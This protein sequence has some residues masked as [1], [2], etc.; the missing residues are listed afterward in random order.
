MQQTNL[1]CVSD[2]LDNMIRRRI[3][4]SRCS[5]RLVKLLENADLHHVLGHNVQYNFL[6]TKVK[7]VKGSSEVAS[8]VDHELSTIHITARN[9][10]F[11][12][13][14]CGGQNKNRTMMQLFL[15]LVESGRF[16]QIDYK[17]QVKGH[18]RNTVD[19]GFAYAKTLFG[20]SDVWSLDDYVDVVERSSTSNHAQNL[21]GVDFHEWKTFLDERYRKFDGMQKFH[22]FRFSKDHPGTVM[23][24]NVLADEW[25]SFDIRKVGIRIVDSR[26]AVLPPRGMS[27]E[28]Q[29]DIYKIMREFAS[30][31][32]K[33]ILCPEPRLEIMN[34]SETIEMWPYLR[35]LMSSSFSI[36]VSFGCFSIPIVF[37]NLAKKS[38]DNELSVASY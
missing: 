9:P 22:L 33:D 32:Y 16:D 21:E 4:E 18:T 12:E 20:K 17:F 29:H 25:Q 38:L 24:K 34:R 8:L 2:K 7:A 14:N 37:S 6:Y 1:W 11:W 3:N 5:L 23:A 30:D 27:E 28:K 13:D 35:T 31:Q 36:S 26:P 19:R 10:V 15:S